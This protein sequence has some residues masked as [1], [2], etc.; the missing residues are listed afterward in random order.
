MRN[1][2]TLQKQ[3]LQHVYYDPFA[4]A[5]V[6]PCLTRKYVQESHSLEQKWRT[7]KSETRKEEKPDYKYNIKIPAVRNGESTL[8]EFPKKYTKCYPKFSIQMLW[9]YLSWHQPT[10]SLWSSVA[11]KNA[12]SPTLLNFT[13]AQA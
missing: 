11:L 10:S 2:L 3:D 12:R 7:R 1:D 13:C 5:W 4:L 8:L 6:F 9:G